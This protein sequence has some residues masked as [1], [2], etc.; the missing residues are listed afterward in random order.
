MEVLRRDVQSRDFEEIQRKKCDQSA[1]KSVKFGGRAD[2]SLDSTV[3]SSSLYL[4]PIMQS[5]VKTVKSVND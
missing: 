1:A 4:V 2:V 3:A 5:A